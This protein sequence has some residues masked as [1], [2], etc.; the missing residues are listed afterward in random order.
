MK[1]KGRWDGKSVVLYRGLDHKRHR[2]TESISQFASDDRSQL[3]ARVWYVS[4]WSRARRKCFLKFGGTSEL[5]L[6]SLVLQ[7]NT[8]SSSFFLLDQHAAVT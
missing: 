7:K 2:V 1:S 5:G 8:S 6:C 3:L 4:I